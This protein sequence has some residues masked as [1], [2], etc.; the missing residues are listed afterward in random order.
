MHNK[1][2]VFG[3]NDYS[4]NLFLTSCIIICITVVVFI[5]SSL[6]SIGLFLA[7][8]KTNYIVL[9]AG[10]ETI[11]TVFVSNI[12]KYSKDN[13]NIND[14]SLEASYDANKPLF[15]IHNQIHITVIC[16]LLVLSVT[17]MIKYVVNNKCHI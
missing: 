16:V 2:Q 3:I 9:T 5:Y 14:I 15:A 10:V 4:F 13:G 17:D 6:L 12:S 1:Q 8:L 7:A 11:K